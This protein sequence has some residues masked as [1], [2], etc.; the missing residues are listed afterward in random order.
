MVHVQ[1]KFNKVQP[2]GSYTKYDK[3]SWV[4]NKFYQA[5]PDQQYQWCSTG[6]EQDN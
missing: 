4:Q 3:E 2:I 6:T 1:F 5:S